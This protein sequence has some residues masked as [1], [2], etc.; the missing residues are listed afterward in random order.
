MLQVLQYNTIV[1]VCLNTGA[2]AAVTRDD[3]DDDDDV[4]FT[5]RLQ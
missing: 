4:T 5:S 2:V 1:T 3:D